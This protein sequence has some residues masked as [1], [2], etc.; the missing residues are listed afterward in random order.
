MSNGVTQQELDSTF[1]ATLAL[2]VARVKDVLVTSTSAQV[3]LTFTPTVSGVF[4]IKNYFTVITGTTNVTITIAYADSVG[5]RTDTL[6]S[7]QSCPPLNY[8][9]VPWSIYAVAGTPIVVT[10]TASVANQVH[11]TSWIVGE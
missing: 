1:A 5:A 9:T 4:D 11:A 10:I 6:L 3:L 7:A 8:N 2:V